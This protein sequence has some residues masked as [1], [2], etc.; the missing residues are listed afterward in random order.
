M[1][2]HRLPS[3]AAVT[4]VLLLAVLSPGVWAFDS[5]STGVDG[6]LNPSASIEVVLPPSGVLNYSSINIPTGVTVTFKRNALNTPVHLLVSGNVTIAGTIDVRGKDAPDI[7]TAGSGLV[8]DDGRAGLAGPGGYD[9][10]SGGRPL[11]F[12]DATKW[13]GAG[14]LGPG[15][16]WGGAIQSPRSSCSTGQRYYS[17]DGVG[18]A[19]ASQGGNPNSPCGTTFSGTAQA[20][21]SSAIQPL[22]G[23]SGGG[24]GAGTASFSGSGGGGGGG[25][26]MIAATGT[27]TLTGSVLA[28]GGQGGGIGGPDSP[29]AGGGGSGGAIRL[30]ATT[31]N[32]TGTLFARG[33]CNKNQGCGGQHQASVGRIRIEG[34]T[35]TFS[36][37][38]TPTASRDVP[39][40]VGFASAPTLRIATIA[41]QPVP[42]NPTGTRDVTFPTA[43]AN[44]VTVG[45]ATTN[46]PPGN[47]IKLRVVP[48]N[49]DP[50]E[51]LS[52]AIAGTTANGT[53]SVNIALPNGASSMLAVASFTVAVAMGESLSRYAQ[54]ERVERIELVASMGSPS[55]A[56]LVTAAGNRHRVPL[57]LLQALGALG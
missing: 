26:L 22:I 38:T 39:G 52:P 34:E 19:Y 47:T 16:G 4:G 46:I 18:A 3:A 57:A 54:N 41:G 49:G 33:G 28:D 20:Y 21:G 6:V 25:A 9:G 51:A 17:V 40:P 5:G 8:A 44:P 48:A 24:G 2:P 31:F 35:V 7:G 50:V 32:G 1:N 27:L 55:E 43:P 42:A 13:P 10:G 23:G 15:G 30:V 56:F 14:G 12:P 45:F 36:G 11:S 53:A 37:S 29:G